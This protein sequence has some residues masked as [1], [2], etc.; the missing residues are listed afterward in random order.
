[1]TP[2]EAYEIIC[3]TYDEKFVSDACR[4]YGTFYGFFVKAEGSDPTERVYVGARMICIDKSSKK[5]YSEEIY[6][7]A[8]KRWRP[9]IV[10][11]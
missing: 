11:I 9:V 6:E 1:M 10:D 5:V 4:D 2:K 7:L 8:G 3:D